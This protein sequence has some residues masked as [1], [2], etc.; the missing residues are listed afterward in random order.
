MSRSN[1]FSSVDAASDWMLVSEPQSF[2]HM[3]CCKKD[4]PKKQLCLLR[5]SFDLSRM[6]GRIGLWKDG[7]LCKV[8]GKDDEKC[9]RLFSNGCHKTRWPFNELLTYRRLHRRFQWLLAW[10]E[11]E[12]AKTVARMQKTNACHARNQAGWCIGC[13]GKSFHFVCIYGQGQNKINMLN[14]LMLFVS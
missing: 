10:G 9:K 1:W 8:S 3:L 6:C 4:V 2:C 5:L 13:I 12:D 11:H 7:R 14:G